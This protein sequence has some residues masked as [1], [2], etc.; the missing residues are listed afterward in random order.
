MFEQGPNTRGSRFD[1]NASSAGNPSPFSSEKVP[2]GSMRSDSGTRFAPTGV[3]IFNEN[4]KISKSGLFAKTHLLVT[5]IAYC[6]SI[7][8][9]QPLRT[10][11]SGLMLRVI[12]EKPAAEEMFEI[13]IPTVAV[14]EL[15]LIR[16]T[17]PSVNV[18]RPFKQI[19]L[20]CPE[21]GVE[22]P[23]PASMKSGLVPT[24][25]RRPDP[26]TT[27]TCQRLQQPKLGFI[28]EGRGTLAALSRQRKKVRVLKTTL[29]FC[30]GGR[31]LVQPT[32]E[33]RPRH[34]SAGVLNLEHAAPC[35]SVRCPK[36]LR[37][38]QCR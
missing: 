27:F 18:A 29:L 16:L 2:R 21:A 8:L 31:I 38:N 19:R 34:A 13:H 25:G 26:S 7:T 30:N 35:I 12:L 37:P 14:Q 4:S 17:K 28:H 36:R 22:E 1:T 32:H 3:S 10:K 24:F 20:V 6:L 11:A 9:R 23:Q 33:K 5:F 15:C